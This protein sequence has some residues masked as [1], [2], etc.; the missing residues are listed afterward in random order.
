MEYSVLGPLHVSN[1]EGAVDIRGAK[2][3]TVLAHLIARWGQAVPS[4][5]LVESLWGEHPPRSAV[6]SLQT[7][8]LRLRNALEPARDGSPQIV[9]TDGNGYRLVADRAD[10]DA[11]RFVLLSER[12]RRALEEGRADLAAETLAEA[13]DLWRGHAYAGFEDTAFGRAESRRLAELRLVAAE[14]RWAAEL[15]L[16]RA[17]VAV[18]ELERLLADQPLRERLWCLLVLAHYRCGGQGDALLAYD[19]ARSRLAEELGVDPGPELRGLHARVLAHDPTLAVHRRA[20]VLP[21]PLVP[22]DHPLVGREVELAVVRRAWDRACAGAPTTVVVRGPSGAG[23]TRLAQDVAVQVAR[24]GRPVML[25][26]GTAPDTQP[27]PAQGDHRESATGPALWVA[28]H[29]P[30]PDPARAGLTLVLTR[31]G[32]VVCGADEVVDLPPLDDEAVESILSGYLPRGDAALALDEVRRRTGGWPGAVHEEGLRLARRAA[33]QRVEAAA[34]RAGR[35]SA[36]LGSAR[37]ELADEVERLIDTTRRGAPGP[38]TSPWR[39]LASYGVADAAWFR[40]RERLVAELV[41]RV[42]GSR[43]LG[44]VGSSGSGKSSAVQAGLLASLAA[45]VLPGSARWRQIVVRPGPHP[46]RE[47]AR[48][49]LGQG[50][51]G[52][53]GRAGLVGPG[54]GAARSRVVLVVDQLEEL[55][56]ACGDPVER[57]TFLDTVVGLVEDPGSTVSVVLVLRADFVG[58]V[59]H[60]RRLAELLA[61]S[62]VLVGTPTPAEVRRMVERPAQR[63]SLRLEDGLADALV[64]DAG[65]EPGL[66]PL[67]STA[68]T[69]LWEHRSGPDLTFAAYVAAGGLHGAIAHLAEAAYAALPPA[70]QEAART[71]LLRLT[72]PG[73]D[74]GVTRRRVAVSEIDELPDAES[75]RHVI[76]VLTRARLLTASDGHVEVAHEALFGR[77]PRLAGWLAEDAARRAVQRRLAVAASEW[78]AEDRDPA[79][80]WR[81]APL[82]SGL[83]VVQS[84]PGEVTTT[85]RAFLDAGREAVDADRRAAEERAATAARQ[86]RR[87]RGVLLGLGVLLVLAMVAGLAAVRSRAEAIQATTSAEAGRLAATA[88]NEDDLD[89]ALLTAVE[90]VGMERSSQTLG[91]LLTL[92]ARSPNVVTQIAASDRFIQAAVSHDR[93]TVYLGENDPL[94]HAVDAATGER[95][96][97]T[98]TSV[99]PSSLDHGPGGL[100]VA[101][102][103]DP[104]PSISVLDPATG[105]EVWSF[106]LA[107]TSAALGEDAMPLVLAGVQWLPDGRVAAATPGG[108]LLLHGDGTFAGTVPWGASLDIESLTAWPDGRVS[109]VTRDGASFVVDPGRPEAAPVPL[110][111]TVLA[112]SAAGELLVRAPSAS[113]EVTIAVHDAATLQR[114]PVTRP[115]RP[116]EVGAATFS[117]D[118]SLLAIGDGELLRLYDVHSGEEVDRYAGHSGFVTDVVFA[119]DGGDVVWTAGRDGSGIAWD[120]GGTRGAVRTRSFPLASSRGDVAARTGVAVALTRTPGNVWFQAAELHLVDTATG[121]DLATLVEPDVCPC[122]LVAADISADGST[123]VAGLEVRVEQGPDGQHVDG[124]DHLVVYDVTTGDLRTTVAVPWHTLGIGLSPDGTRAVVGGHTGHGVVDLARGRLVSATT[125]DDESFHE[126]TQ[127]AEVSPDGTRGVVGRNGRVVLVD[128]A[129][130]DLLTEIATA[131]SAPGPGVAA[132]PGRPL[133]FAWT[134]D[135]RTVVAGDSHGSV[136]FLDGDTLETV[137]PTRTLRGGWIMDLEVAPDGRLL[138]SLGT[139]GSVVLWDTAGWTPLGQPVS[140]ARHWGLLAFS[141]DA[142]TLRSLH[143]TG[144]LVELSTDPD[145]WVRNACRV[146][147]RDLTAEEAA[148]VLPDREPSRTCS[149]DAPPAR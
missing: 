5:A 46:M 48:Q 13:L 43:L 67:L 56:T 59:A 146:A 49:D 77:W 126:V 92:L 9:V 10:V 73:E 118:G 28:D 74:A 76:A 109:L 95:L 30:A 87:L 104:F 22:P 144:E 18:A 75:L 29:V 80:L 44:V 81:G 94:V 31:P 122:T 55:W 101:G 111:G 137:A 130:G 84:H 15:E 3:R 90:A 93:R 1:G 7:Y 115:M 12:G 27:G 78:E 139:D 72:G 11:E 114:V 35:S 16:G 133:T 113:G 140:D 24:A 145:A 57:A 54:P 99:Q 120:L 62:T 141:P 37:A 58:E 34:N 135:G 20:P 131:P 147:N 110:P 132:N 45:D 100:L 134:P 64:T 136:S 40:G 4:S 107:E 128:M 60:H 149:A 14:D 142:G 41:A 50:D 32:A 19:R 70:G 79:R 121:E 98:R 33:T 86:N 52:G 66:L 124:P 117:P 125:G 47:L 88:V 89:L 96:W 138:A 97:R 91:A 2:E 21:G 23:A 65:T 39:G 148:I 8:V 53:D 116:A 143:E 25:L 6:K 36:S 108:L 129:T 17:A 38:D 123:A 105:T 83:E 42:A 61:D 102:L 106:G 112:A 103:G 63:A 127:S 71:L 26:P 69:H 82:Q 51:G 68:M 119:G 85:E